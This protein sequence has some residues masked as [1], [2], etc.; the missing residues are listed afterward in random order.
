MCHNAPER[1][2]SFSLFQLMKELLQVSCMSFI[3]VIFA[4]SIKCGYGYESKSI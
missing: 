3:Y 2:L 1:L 4:I